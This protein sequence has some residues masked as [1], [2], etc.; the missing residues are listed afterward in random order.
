[1]FLS[2]VSLV[3]VLLVVLVVAG[4]VIYA[5]AVPRMREGG[6]VLTPDGERLARSVRQSV[7]ESVRHATRRVLRR[8]VGHG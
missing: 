3:V 6:T 2:A 7:Q 8:R 1:M 4:G 5:V